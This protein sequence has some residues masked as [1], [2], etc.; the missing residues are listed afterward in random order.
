M[1]A[2]ASSLWP[3]YNIPLGNETT[4]KE[5]SSHLL[6]IDVSGEFY[7][8]LD[9]ARWPPT[10]LQWF[11]T[12][13]ATNRWRQYW[14]REE[15]SRELRWLLHN[16]QLFTVGKFIA[17][18]EARRESKATVGNVC[19][20]S[21][22]ICDIYSCDIDN[23]MCDKGWLLM[24]YEIILCTALSLQL[25]TTIILLRQILEDHLPTQH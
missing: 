10:L 25:Y 14:S 22:S 3:P 24:S 18:S 15:G 11:D 2:A 13:Y 20:N 17:G 7:L 23:N 6:S 4:F 12:V 19:N 1:A 8:L 21:G 9:L 5:L 16:I